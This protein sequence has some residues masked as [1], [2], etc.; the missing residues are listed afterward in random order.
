MNDGKARVLGDR[1]GAESGDAQGEGNGDC[2]FVE[3]V[4]EE[5][6]A[7]EMVLVKACRM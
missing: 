7:L 2:R 1:R 4:R 3:G 5:A 6:V